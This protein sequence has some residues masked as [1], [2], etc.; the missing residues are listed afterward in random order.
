LKSLCYDARSEKRQ[1]MNNP[2]EYVFVK[3]F[4]CSYTKLE[5]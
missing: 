4:M 2:G 1:I 5:V 3:S